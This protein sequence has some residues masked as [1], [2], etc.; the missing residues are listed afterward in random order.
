[1]VDSSNARGKV[2]LVL[3]WTSST[4]Q[5][6]RDLPEL[7]KTYQKYH[8]NGLEL[9]GVSL[10]SDKAALEA[11]LKDNPL[12]WAQIYEPGGMDGRL[13]NEFGIISMPTMILTDAEGK[14]V[15]RGI[16]TS[17]ELEKQLE[18]LGLDRSAA[19]ARGR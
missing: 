5:A 9:I 4:D 16:R 17:A 11:F 6:K 13:A 10:D 14:V 1:V 2:L 18:K 12:P 15:T 7:V 19:T 3:F 8:A